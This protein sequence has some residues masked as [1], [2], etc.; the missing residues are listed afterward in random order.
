MRSHCDPFRILGIAP[1][2]PDY[3]IVYDGQCPVCERF[4]PAYLRT[5]NLGV[6]SVLVDAREH[7]EL[8]TVL[9]KEG[10][11]LN[12]DAALFWNSRWYEGHTAL[13]V[14]FSNSAVR[15]VRMQKA[16]QHIFAATYPF[17]RIGRL[18][19]LRILRRSLI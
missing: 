1:P 16:A 17:L 5:L 15:S 3:L 8:V 19:L 6:H 4:F 13:S 11:D 18:L 7:P 12:R 2:F 9:S 10:I 14:L